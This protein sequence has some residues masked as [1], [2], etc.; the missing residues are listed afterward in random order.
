MTRADGP[1]KEENDRKQKEALFRQ[2]LGV[3]IRELRA[4]RGLSQERVALEAG[5]TQ[6]QIS[7]IETGKRNPSAT[8]LWN[9]AQALEVTLAELL[10]GLD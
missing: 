6:F 5:L 2:R 3:K 4:A 1:I 9:L 10:E 7:G 8:T